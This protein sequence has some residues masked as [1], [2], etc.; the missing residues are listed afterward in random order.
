MFRYALSTW[1]YADRSLNLALRD[2]KEAGFSDIELWAD[3]THL[4]PRY[5]ADSSQALSLVRT[6]GLNVHSIHGPFHGIHIG[7]DDP[8]KVKETENVITR[9]IEFCHELESEYI[10]VHPN[11]CNFQQMNEIAENYT[12]ELFQNLADRA[13]RLGVRILVENLPYAPFPYNSMSGLIDMFPDPRIGLCLDIGHAFLNGFSVID[14]IDIAAPRLYSC[15]V[16]NNDGKNDSHSN[17]YDGLI[18]MDI[19]LDRLTC[20]QQVTAVL[21]I[22]GSPNPEETLEEVRRACLIRSHREEKREND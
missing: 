1:L 6:S 15:H 12:K 8:E 20:L 10:V 17:I 18:E 3:N 21:E 5:L 19:I 9:T 4:D 13:Q 2:F 7:S 16:S 22:T 14:E 11:T